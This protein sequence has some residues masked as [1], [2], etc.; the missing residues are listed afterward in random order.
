VQRVELDEVTGRQWCE[1]VGD[2]PE[3]W[4]GVAEGMVWREKQRHVGIRAPDGRLVALAGAVRAD[5]EVDGAPI[6]QVL[7]IGGVFVARSA[8]GRGLTATL[9]EGFWPKPDTR[10]PS[11]RCCSAGL[12]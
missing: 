3:P 9:L 7:G 10:A 5:V 6:F 1:L 12:S 4:G 11:G 2:E 8:R